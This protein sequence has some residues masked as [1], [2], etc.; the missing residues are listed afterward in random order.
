MSEE[1]KRRHLR[2]PGN[3]L[4]LVIFLAVVAGILVYFALNLKPNS[5]TPVK[6][7]STKSVAKNTTLSIEKPTEDNGQYFS[8]IKIDTGG[9]LVSKVQLELSYNPN[10]IRNVE[11][12]P[13]N[14]FPNSETLLESIDEVDGRISYVL[15]IPESDEEIKG[16][17]NIAEIIFQ[18]IASKSAVIQTEINF[19]PKTSVTGKKSN[20]SLLKSTIDLST[21]L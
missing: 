8:V 21:S 12:Y 13:S 17:G 18:K 14:F 20:D 1:N 6:T 11:I 4:L 16:T 19:L 7:E 10:D 15:S 3:T 5:P 9:D 2:V